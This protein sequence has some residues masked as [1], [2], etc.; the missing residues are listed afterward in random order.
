[1]TDEK[2]VKLENIEEERALF[3][4]NDQVIKKLR[5][6]FGVKVV[7]R[8]GS[9]RITGEAPA[10]EEAH[11]ALTQ[12]L[13]QLRVR[14]TLSLDDALRVLDADVDADSRTTV[15]RNLKA[16]IVGDVR[17]KTSGQEQYVAR[18]DGFDVVFC[19][20]PAGTGKTYLAVAKAIQALK[21]G[22]VKRL[23][24][25]RPAVEAG[26]KLGFLPGDY[27]EKVNP[28]LRPLYDALNDM[29][30]FAQIRRYIE[31][32]VIEVVPLAY[33]RGRTLDNSFI[34][35]DEAQNT[36]PAQMK[37]FLTRMGLHSKAVVTGDIT[38]VDL[39]RDQ[40]SGLAHAL[41]VL[42]GVKGIGMVKLDRC[43]VVRH[44]V[45][46]AI[47]DAYEREDAARENG[48]QRS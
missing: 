8:E 26:E 40:V 6:R 1:M 27:R 24:L 30:D 38:Q 12:L 48:Q 23:I 32:D 7:S 41:S 20:G 22:V 11:S 17:P 4:R 25:V 16:A 5:E 36:T 35:L 15:E 31:R 34:I 18:V 9:L 29:L 45:V 33:M 14:G 43:D 3:G 42:T 28:Y 2:R 46:Q 37:M 10:V 21:R 39:P 47:V 44:R 19:I 13:R